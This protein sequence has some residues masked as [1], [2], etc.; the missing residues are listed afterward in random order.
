MPPAT[1][2]RREKIIDEDGNIL[3]LV[4]WRVPSTP[5]SP[6][7]VRYRLAFVR[8]GELTPAVLY[9]NHLPKGDHR[10]IEGVEHA[11]VFVD[12]DQLVVD[13]IGDVRRVTGENRWPRR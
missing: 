10:H 4:I 3:E 13:F 2:I 1:P 7:G 12:V 11:Y 8:A 9:D 5:H 6:A